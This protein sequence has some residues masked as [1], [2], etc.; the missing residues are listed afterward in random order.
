MNNQR[1]KF[2]NIVETER[3]IES[4]HLFRFVIISTEI[5]TRVSRRSTIVKYIIFWS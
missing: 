4:S 1:S 2:I 3:G 5:L